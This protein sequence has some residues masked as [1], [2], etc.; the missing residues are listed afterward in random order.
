MANK[1]TAKKIVANI[2]KEEFEDALSAY[3]V[4]HAKES[5]I[6]S[7]MDEKITKIREQYADQLS[8]LREELDKTYDVVQTYCVEN[9][10]TL[11]TK[12]K[13]METTHG[14]IGFRTGTPKLKTLRGFT[15]ASVLTLMKKV[16]PD[17]VR[18][19][20]EPNK[21]LL[22]ADREKPEIKTVFDE[23][24]VRVDQDETFYIDL[25]KEAEVAM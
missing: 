13:S 17:Y 2:S 5:G 7:K 8:D 15:W 25:K 23:I 6:T 16:L 14:V 11:F 21:E 9:E 19:K 1:R 3:A 24:G 22:L 4:A 12:K 10:D 18:V 20:E